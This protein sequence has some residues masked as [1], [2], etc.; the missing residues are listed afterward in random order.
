MANIETVRKVAQSLAA[1]LN[2]HLKSTGFRVM[3]HQQA[4]NKGNMSLFVDPQSGRNKQRLYIEPATKHGQYKIALSGITLEARQKEFELIFGRECDG[5]DHPDS[6]CPYWY[7]D[8]PVLVRKS[9][10]LYVQ[11]FMQFNPGVD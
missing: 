11:P 5:Y 10:Y 7:V 2:E 3:F 9:A 4:V 1:E 8:D 6:T